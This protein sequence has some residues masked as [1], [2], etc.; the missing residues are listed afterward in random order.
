MFTCSDCKSAVGPKVKPLVIIESVRNVAYVNKKTVFDEY[1]RAKEETIES[2]GTEIARERKVCPACAGLE[3]PVTPATT[4]RKA[5]QFEEPLP[6]PLRPCLID[7][8]AHNAVG[9]A[10]QKTVR[11]KQET[12]GNFATIKS[13]IERN[14]KFLF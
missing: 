8:A 3:Q 2:N 14:P 12:V 1:D 4:V 6:E 9:R 13:F 5:H 10:E 7:I 11:A